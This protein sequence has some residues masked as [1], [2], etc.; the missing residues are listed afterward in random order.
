MTTNV[1]A[2]TFGPAGF[3]APAE[4]DI[5]AGRLDDI[6]AAFG[7]LNPA[8]DTPQGQLASSETACIGAQNDMF[9][10][11]ASQ[12]DP[13]FAQGRMQDAIGRIY[14]IERKPAQPT[15][16]SCLCT[17]AQGVTIDAGRQAQDASGNVYVCLQAGTFDASGHMMLSFANT[18]VGPIPCPAGTLNTIIQ[19]LNGWDTINN[20]S[21][22]V[23]GTVVESRTDFEARRA[24]SVAQNSVGSIP[25]IRGAVLAVPGVIDAFVTENTANGP[26][27]I[28]GVSIGANSVYVAVAGGAAADVA[29]AIWTKKAPGCAYTGTTTVSVVDTNPLYLPPYPTYPV[30]YVIPV[31]LEI[32]FSV[33]IANSPLV[34]SNATTLIQNAIVGAFAGLDG[35]PR[36]RIGVAQRASRYYACV[37]TLGA[38]AQVV[39]I[40][41]GSVNNVSAVFTGSVAGNILTVSAL[42]SG[43]GPIAVGQTLDDTT[44]ALVE[45]TQVLSQVTGAAGGV[46]T[47]TVSSVQTI[48]SE[49]MTAAVPTLFQVGVNINQ[50]PVINPVNI[51]VSLL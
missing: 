11:Y 7:S 6:N 33:V 49:T 39:S 42:G 32:L 15:V 10:F 21:D 30:S 31:G 28:G 47:Y 3:V 24:L 48:A 14:F 5:L 16:V 45:G 1:P 9:L 51:K 23:P 19:I 46:G 18:A 2:P 50:I 40:E 34:P 25:A 35:G 13:A 27:T 38:W 37:A 4:S 44:Q 36:A 12:T 41:I 26:N 22:G 29:R 8:L 43:S 17:G 20:P